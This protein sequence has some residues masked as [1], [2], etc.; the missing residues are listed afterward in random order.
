MIWYCA[1]VVFRGTHALVGVEQVYDRHEYYDE[2]A[3]ALKRLAAPVNEIVNPP[4]RAKVAQLDDQQEKAVMKPGKRSIAIHEAGHAV[5]ARVLGIGVAYATRFSTGPDNRGD[6]STQSAAYRDG[7]ADISTRIK[8][9]EDDARVALA[10]PLAQYKHKLVRGGWSTIE[11]WDIDYTKVQNCA[12]N[13]VALRRGIDIDKLTQSGE[14]TFSLD[15]SGFDEADDLLKQLCTEA[16]QLVDQ[17]WSAIKR[18]AEGLLSQH[19]L[20][21]AEIDALIS[22]QAAEDRHHRCCYARL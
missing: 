7:K 8:A 5:V 16:Q 3:D 14:T 10:G 9:L 17:H 15:A 11:G 2:K 1:G 19:S 4:P 22:D 13:V 20:T 21:E 18:V 12:G 6:V